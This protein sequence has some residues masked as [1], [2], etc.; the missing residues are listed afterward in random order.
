MLE[1]GLAILNNQWTRLM[2]AALIAY[3]VGFYSVEQPDIAAIE[4]NAALGRDAE[5]T[6]LLAQKEREHEARV[7]ASVAAGQAEPA[8]SA[9]R[10][11]RMQ[12]CA[13]S[14]SC[15]ERRGS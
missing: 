8:T 1:I 2:A 5:W 10:A 13:A 12:Q 11:Q 7:E 14:P 6:R 4:R 3:L 15:R 9:D